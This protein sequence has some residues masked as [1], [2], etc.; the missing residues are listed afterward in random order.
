M[1]PKW[2]QTYA[3]LQQRK[4]T[5]TVGNLQINTATNECEYN[6]DK[7][8]PLCIYTHSIAPVTEKH[9]RIALPNSLV[10]TR[11]LIS[12]LSEIKLHVDIGN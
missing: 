11:S 2:N 1:K 10:K 3:K 5:Y 7:I 6:P 4:Q 9:T 8:F 12:E